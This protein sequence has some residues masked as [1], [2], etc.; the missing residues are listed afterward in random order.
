MFIRC[1]LCKVSF[2]PAKWVVIVS[3]FTAAGTSVRVRSWGRFYMTPKPMLNL[4]IPDNVGD[5]TLMHLLPSGGPGTN[6][7]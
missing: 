4:C 3:R 2:N 6:I 5:A 1:L 7:K